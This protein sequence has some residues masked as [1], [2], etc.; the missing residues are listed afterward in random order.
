MGDQ[1]F[2]RVIVCH[3]VNLVDGSLLRRTEIRRE[4]IVLQMLRQT[5]GSCNIPHFK[6]L[7]QGL[8]LRKLLFRRGHISH[9]CGKL[10]ERLQ[11]SGEVCEKGSVGKNAVI[12]EDNGVFPIQSAELL[13]RR[14]QRFF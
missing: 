3:K 7:Q 13:L 5:Y 11:F 6:L 10:V 1:Q 9:R 14:S 12:V 4:D 2:R 8:Q